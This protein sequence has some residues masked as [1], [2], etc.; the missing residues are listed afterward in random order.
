MAKRVP[1]LRQ[2][3]TGVWFVRF[4]GRD[5]YFTINHD[6]SLQ[7]YTEKLSEWVRRE[8]TKKKH[9]TTDNI[10]IAELYAAFIDSRAVDVT[11]WTVS[12][13][14]NHLRRFVALWGAFSAGSIDARLLQAFKADLGKLE[15]A[16]RTQRHDL[17]A[18]KAMLQWGV[19]F[20]YLAP[21]N[22]A[23]VKPPPLPPPKRRGLPITRIRSIIR[24][25][26]GT[27]RGTDSLSGEPLIPDSRVAPWLALC[28]LALLRPM[29]AV[30]LI[31]REGE[32]I[33]HG[34]FQLSVSKTQARTQMPRC[35]VL[36]EQA[37]MWFNS[38]SP[39]WA[40]L[41]GFEQAVRRSVGPGLPHPLRHSAASHLLQAGVAR[42]EIEIILGHL[43]S[44]VSLTY[45]PIEWQPLRTSAGILRVE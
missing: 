38:A 3:K 45:A 18:V 42:A 40:S 14:R 12:W 20:E 34:I 26:A 25:A 17:S 15:L 30:R 37:L 16:P 8:E 22:L 9:N 2:H 29:E 36:S 32:F 19:N 23:A 39:H 27:E 11:S 43:P 6:E 33:E 35:I 44:R 13:H 1:K 4:G 41:S 21:V 5:H 10:T 24:L 31:H 7:A 28:Y